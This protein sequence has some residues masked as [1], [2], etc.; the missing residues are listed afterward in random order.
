MLTDVPVTIVILSISCEPPSE[1][2]VVSLSLLLS[3][4]AMAFPEAAASL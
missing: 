4:L 2:Y 3:I 1:H